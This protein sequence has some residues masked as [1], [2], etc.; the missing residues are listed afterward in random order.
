M[1]PAAVQRSDSGPGQGCRLDIKGDVAEMG[2]KW[3]QLEQKSGDEWKAGRRTHVSVSGCREMAVK[4]GIWVWLLGD[5]KA[6]PEEGP[7]A[8]GA[9][10]GR[11]GDI[12]GFGPQLCGSLEAAKGSAQ[13]SSGENQGWRE[14]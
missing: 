9:G 14:A 6:S 10:W 13:G 3:V 2:P 1:T 11:E 8:G 5:D 4:G 7:P 12:F